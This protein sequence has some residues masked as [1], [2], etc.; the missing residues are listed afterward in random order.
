MNSDRAHE[1]SVG[2]PVLAE[3]AEFLSIEIEYYDTVVESIA[4]KYV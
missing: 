3:C 4:Y 2:P 1:L